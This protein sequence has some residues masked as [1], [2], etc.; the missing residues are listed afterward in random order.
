MNSVVPILHGINQ[1]DTEPAG[2]YEDPRPPK[3]KGE[4]KAKNQILAF[5]YAKP[6]PRRLFSRLLSD[7]PP[8]PIFCSSAARRQAARRRDATAGASSDKLASSGSVTR[9]T[10]SGCSD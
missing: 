4:K 2:V 5:L 7:Q 1:S 6:E 8:P 10:S 3:E 9:L